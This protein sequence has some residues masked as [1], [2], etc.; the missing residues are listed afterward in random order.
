MCHSI[1][2]TKMFKLGR[3]ILQTEQDNIIGVIVII[4]DV[5]DVTR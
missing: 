4:I 2:G 3:M 1:F 5:H